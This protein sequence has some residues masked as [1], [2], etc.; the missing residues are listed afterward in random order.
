VSGYVVLAGLGLLWL[1]GYLIACRIW[2]FTFCR[3][4]EG[5]GRFASPS[6]RAWRP[7]RRCKGSGSHVR[8]GRRLLTWL[9][10]TTDNAAV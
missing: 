9:S 3:K 10:N 8:T 1:G 7:C 5:V 4:C 2:P 6:G